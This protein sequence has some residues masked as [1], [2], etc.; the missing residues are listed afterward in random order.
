MKVSRGRIVHTL[1]PWSNGHSEQAAIVTHV[2]GDGEMAGE[3]VNLT[4]FVDEGMPLIQGGVPWF[5]TRE[6]ALATLQATQNSLVPGARACWFPERD[7]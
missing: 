6:V 3:L 5:P 1:G 4:I 7:E 2:H